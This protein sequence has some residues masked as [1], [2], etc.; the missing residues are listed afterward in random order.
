MGGKAAKVKLVLFD[1]GAMACVCSSPSSGD[2]GTRRMVHI[3]GVGVGL[4]H[5]TMWRLT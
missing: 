1:T 3:V 5:H 2:E 4:P